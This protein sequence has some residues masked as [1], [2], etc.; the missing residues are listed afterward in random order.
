MSQHPQDPQPR[1]R[2][3]G[4]PDVFTARDLRNRSGELLRDAEEGRL[5]VITKH[6]RPMI[7]AVP[8]D[9]RL[10]IQ[11][12]HRHVALSLFE[13]GQATLAQSARLAGLAQEAF[14][15]LLGELGI[16]AIDYPPE[17]LAEELEAAL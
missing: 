4:T 7:L 8:F 3:A 14:V 10:L 13:S 2:P 16:P 1:D 17:E 15:E 6:G 11:G 5:A 12:V 9:Q